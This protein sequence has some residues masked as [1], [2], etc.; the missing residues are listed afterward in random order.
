MNEK[1]ITR[2]SLADVRI[3]KE[4]GESQTSPNAPEREAFERGFWDKAEM[5]VGKGGIQSVHLKLE[6]E[7]FEFFK[8]RGKGHISRMQE[9]LKAYAH[10]H[11]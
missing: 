8:E 7:V 4:R 6:K 5:R 11:K 10:A 9:V 2:A 3:R 1:A